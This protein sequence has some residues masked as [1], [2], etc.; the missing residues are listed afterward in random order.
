MSLAARFS[1][2]NTIEYVKP[3]NY[4]KSV[5]ILEPKLEVIPGAFAEYTYSGIKGLTIMGGFRADFLSTK[6]PDTTIKNTF[7]SPRFHVQYKFDENNSLR[8]SAG[9]GFRISNIHAEDIGM[10]ASSRAMH[11]G[12]ND[13]T[14]EKLKPEEAWN[15]GIN[16]TSVFNLFGYDFTLNAEYYRTEF[17]NQ[18]IMNMERTTTDMYVYNLKG[19]S[20]SNSFQVDLSFDPIY[21]L[22]LTGAFRLNDVKMTIDDKL[23]DKPLQS[24]TK[25]FLNLVYVTPDDDWNFDFTAEY[26]GSGRIVPSSSNLVGYRMDDNFPSF[27]MLHSQITKKFKGFDIYLGGE[28]LTNYTQKNVIISPNEP[29]G[30]YFEGALVWGPIVGR[31][32]YLGTR[33]SL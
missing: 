10:F 32:L 6:Y 31:I 21:G 28:N 23:L 1:N 5:S 13:T 12:P 27:V 15:Y 26:N 8:L 17:L 16:G 9:K 30:K 22:T 3:I 29:H 25:G 20:Y 24:R 19:K 14:K 11:M 33:L 7:L 2:D 4:P 18:V